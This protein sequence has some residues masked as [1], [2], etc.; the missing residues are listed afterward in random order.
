MSVNFFTSWSLVSIV[1]HWYK[2]VFILIESSLQYHLL[3]LSFSSH[4]HKKYSKKIWGKLCH[5]A[6][7]LKHVKAEW[8][9]L[10]RYWNKREGYGKL[11]EWINREDS[12]E[13]RKVEL[14]IFFVA[15]PVFEEIEKSILWLQIPTFCGK[16]SLL[17]RNID[18]NVNCLRRQRKHET[19]WRFRARL[20]SLV[21]SNE[22]I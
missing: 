11:P 21:A 17:L 20:N 18:W 9:K 5:K 6:P 19:T 22:A 1:Y 7:E 10:R 2:Y 12:F 4:K 14:K 16:A 15:Q 13:R 8:R 3:I